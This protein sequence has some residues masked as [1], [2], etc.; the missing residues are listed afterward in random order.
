MVKQ[1][2]LKLKSALERVL[3]RSKWFILVYPIQIKLSEDVVINNTRLHQCSFSLTGSRYKIPILVNKHFKPC[4]KLK[5]APIPYR[6]FLL[7]IPKSGTYLIAKILENMGIENCNVH[8][9]THNIQDN[10]FAPKELL[11]AEPSR[12]QVPIPFV[13]STRLIYPGQFAFGHIPCFDNEQKLLKDFKK[14][15]SFRELRDM[16]IS[17]VRYYSEI[18]RDIDLAFNKD[19]EKRRLVKE[20]LNTPLGT[21]KVKLWFQLWGIEYFNLV[22]SM[23][24]WKEVEDVLSLRFETIMGDD[25]EK[26][27][28]FLIKRIGDFL[29]VK[30]AHEK[31]KYI[32]SSSIGS[33]T[34]TYSGRRT[35]HARW[36]NEELE[37]LFIS[38]G[39]WNLNQRLGYK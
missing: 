20:F 4:F 24:P 31:I 32:L 22:Q 39:F 11:Q 14:I 36:W 18:R 34:I 13:L 21:Q 6:V 15:F 29:G 12:F 2:I 30:L 25:G 37:E 9:S 17:T 23:L 26:N 33:W 10:R 1:F 7:S 8:I 35:V 16:I 3:F 5:Q 27:Q 28:I 38:Y 19:P